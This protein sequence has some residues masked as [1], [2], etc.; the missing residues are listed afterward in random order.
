M[1]WTIVGGGLTGASLAYELA[2][3]HQA[4]VLLEPDHPLQGATRWSYGGVAYWSGTTPFTQTLCQESHDRY[5]AL[6][7]ELELDPQYRETHL[8]IP[9]EIDQDPEAI[10]H[11]YQSF[12]PKPDLLT[13]TEAQHLEPLLNPA[14][15][16]GVLRFPHG[17][18]N[19]LALT[20]AYHH[21]FTALGG[22]IVPRRAIRWR[23]E[24]DR[25]G[26][27][28]IIAIETDQDPI[29][30]DRIVVCA[31][32]G[33]RSLLAALGLALPLY[34]TQAEVIETVPTN[35]RLNGVILPAN[36]SRLRLEAQLTDPD[37]VAAWTQGQ[38]L[39]LP[40]VL[41]PGAVQFPELSGSGG[42]CALGQI[43]RL[44]T[45]ADAPVDPLASETQ[46]RE[47]IGRLLPDLAALPGTW[48][49]CNVSFSADG[50]PLIGALDPWVNLFLFSGFTSPF[51]LVPALS[52]R[53]ADQLLGRSDGELEAFGVNRFVGSRV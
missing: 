11:A 4:V 44:T 49:C 51:A 6:L 10:Y 15:L 32:A 23:T 35:L 47:T 34:F 24:Q 27:G 8:L 22:T 26:Q 1:D 25:T 17:H 28:R 18:V 31:G 29:Q 12:S 37:W 3:R 41:E 40:P 39:N 13:P 21:A 19:P 7:T 16:Q 14:P 38:P 5:H 9:I 50:F 30:S 45:P 52:V 48:R 53:F 33:G 2:K 46:I 43:S 20:Q 42:R 36:Q